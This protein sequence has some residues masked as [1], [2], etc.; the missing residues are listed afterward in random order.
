MFARA[1]D[2]FREAIA[3][4]PSYAAPYSGLADACFNQAM[5]GACPPAEMI[6][7]AEAAARKAL[8]LDDTSAE[9]HCSMGLIEGG[10]KWNTKRCEFELRRCTELNPSYA[11]G[12][13]KYGTSFLSPLGRFEEAQDYISRALE[14]DPLSP[15]LQAD[16]AL[17][18]AFRDQPD[19]FETEARKVL[20]KDPAV[21]KLHLYLINSLGSSGHW[22]AAVDAADTACAMLGENPYV[23][24]YTA[25]AYEG[26][27]QHVQAQAIQDR[28]LTKARTQYM[29]AVALA[30]THL[31][32]DSNAVFEK[33]EEAYERHEPLLRYVIWQ[34]FAFRGLHSDSRFQGLK[35]RVGL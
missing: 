18:F 6:R 4:D 14:L 31:H 21:S 2:L 19:R 13:A 35:K 9:A 8:E 1:A 11:L 15:N 20:Q 17:N 32:S 29:P 3:C 28:L 33:L 25:W 22:S 30:V 12:L 27:G 24:A 34:S 10:L 5:H 23:L 16:L 7:Q 26:S